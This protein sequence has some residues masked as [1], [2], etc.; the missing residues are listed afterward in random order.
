MKRQFPGEDEAIEEF[1]KLLSVCQVGMSV[2]G[3]LKA[4]PESDRQ[5]HSHVVL[6]FPGETLPL[7]PSRN[8]PKK[9]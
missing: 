5:S 6:H 2:I 4:L 8:Q 7:T 3:V 9:C 1:F